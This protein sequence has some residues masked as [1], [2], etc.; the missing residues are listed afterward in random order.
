MTMRMRQIEDE[1]GNWI[2]VPTATSFDVMRC[3]GEDCGNAH[4]LLRDE[5]GVCFA[6]LSLSPRQAQLIAR[7]ADEIAEAEGG[8]SLQ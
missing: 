2:T 3:S 8:H 4:V 7:I 1:D 6:E 5:T